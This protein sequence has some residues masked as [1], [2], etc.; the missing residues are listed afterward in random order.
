MFYYLFSK[1]NGVN[2]FPYYVVTPNIYA[3][4]TASGTL[5]DVYYKT[6]K[7][8][9]IIK[10]SLFSNLLGYKVCN[11]SFF[12]K[13]YKEKFD[14]NIF[15][16]FFRLIF[17]ILIEFEFILRRSFLLIMKNLF[18]KNLSE[19]MGFPG[20]GVRDLYNTERYKHNNFHD[21]NYKSI[22]KFYKKKIFNV[23]LKIDQKK[24]DQYE[25][26][27][28]LNNKKYVCIHVRNTNY[29]KDKNRRS[30]RNS[31]IH[32]YLTTIKFLI[33]EGYYV[34]RLGDTQTDEINYS[35][36]RFIDH[37]KS[38]FSG[39]I[40]DLYLI[41]NSSFLICTQSGIYDTARLFQKPILITNMVS[42]FSSYTPS[43]NSRGIFKTIK[44]NGKKLDIKN[45]T[46]LPFYEYLSDYTNARDI[47]MIENTPQ[48]IKKATKEFL[49]LIQTNNFKLNNKQKKLN[50]SLQK[51]L[52]YI[53]NNKIRIKNKSESDLS[54][55]QSLKMICY[56]KS[57]K[58]SFT[59]SY[60]NN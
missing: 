43:E 12:D 15:D 45:Y 23:K 49:N 18:K 25:L 57:S 44:L 39:G 4:G 28:K 59:N 53:Y 1:L 52:E 5:L 13:I 33:A 11:H 29:R 34:V 9:L 35:H 58:G 47:Q 6:N 20:I 7:K 40:M 37:G 19:E 51:K 16:R 42:L 54:Q 14:L 36:K 30:Y 55:R 27:K 31:K 26:I 2:F 21:Q 3:I 48:E 10:T 32:N 41:K 46:N 38:R 17:R 24:L 22:K 50:L 60:L 56:F 8:V